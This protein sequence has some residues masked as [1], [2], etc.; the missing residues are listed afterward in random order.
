MLFANS[1]ELQE[2]T[3]GH[4]V[5]DTGIITDFLIVSPKSW[6]KSHVIFY[7]S[8]KLYSDRMKAKAKAN[9]FF[10][11]CRLFFDLFRWFF[12]LFPFRL[13]WIGPYNTCCTKQTILPSSRVIIEF[14]IFWIEL[15][16]FVTLI[17]GNV[18]G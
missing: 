4:P 17:K 8:F 3:S 10:H 1:A 13:V 7:V 2:R 16:E 6:K 9:I 11:V 5:S 15:S 14:L 12:N 18:M